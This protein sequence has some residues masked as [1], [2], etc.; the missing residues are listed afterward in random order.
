MQRVTVFRVADGEDV[1]S[2][3][4][5]EGS[6]RDE[7]DVDAGQRQGVLHIITAIAEHAKSYHEPCHVLPAYA[8]YP[9]C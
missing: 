5:I 7:T 1:V 6:A 4:R 2:L 9:A 3:G 8:R